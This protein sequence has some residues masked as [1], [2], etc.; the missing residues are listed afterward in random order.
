MST[1]HPPPAGSRPLSLRIGRAHRQRTSILTL[2]A[3]VASAA[4]LQVDLTGPGK[5]ISPD[6]LGIFYED[7][8]HAADGGL[9]AELIQN[10]T[11]R[12]VLTGPSADAVNEDGRPPGVRPKAGST[13]LSAHFDYTAP[14]NSLTIL[15]VHRC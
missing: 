3:G 1:A 5:A 9:Y 15:R 14:P 8:D 4:E 7:H 2:A 11:E 6:L 12:I 10:P 13:E